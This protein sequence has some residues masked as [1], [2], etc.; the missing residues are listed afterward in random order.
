MS[1]GW[2]LVL[3]AVSC[4]AAKTRIQWLASY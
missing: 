1:S 3:A 2:L 4:Q